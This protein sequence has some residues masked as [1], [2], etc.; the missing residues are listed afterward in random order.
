MDNEK[1]KT[2]VKMSLHG[3]LKVLNDKNGS[4]YLV[5]EIPQKEIAPSTD[6][7][8]GKI[9]DEYLQNLSDRNGSD[10]FHV[11]ILNP[12][13][14]GKLSKE[15]DFQARLEGLL[16][17]FGNKGVSVNVG[18][19]GTAKDDK[20]D[21]Q[22]W[23]LVLESDK[24]Q[25]ARKKLFGLG[26]TDLH[27]TLA[28][29]NHDVFGVSKGPETKIY[30]ARDIVENYIE[31]KTA[32]GSPW[33]PSKKETI[34]YEDDFGK[35]MG[36]IDIS[37]LFYKNKDGTL[38]EILVAK[39]SNGE[40]AVCYVAAEGT[41]DHIKDMLTMDANR[42]GHDYSLTDTL[43]RSMLTGKDTI[44]DKAIQYTILANI[45]QRN[46]QESTSDRLQALLNSQERKTTAGRLKELASLA[47]RDEQHV[48][49]SPMQGGAC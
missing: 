34:F 2:A 4:P 26:H 5:L 11:S 44:R 20:K 1:N 3:E 42:L 24:M 47:G 14:Y 36:E 17:E 38:D 28:F 43:G 22:A 27:T 9:P 37:Q 10:N 19:I 23:Y 29:K 6:F 48:N 35:K 32:N 8:S 39:H 46:Q 16:S 13:E 40:V 12:L 18:G 15:E 25:D 21:Y 31:N 49:H 41:Y 7:L 33:I 30:T 45:E